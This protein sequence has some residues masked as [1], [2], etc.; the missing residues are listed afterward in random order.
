[1]RG[2]PRA[3]GCAP[4]DETHVARIQEA[5]CEFTQGQ[6]DQEVPTA[7]AYQLDGLTAEFEALIQP[8]Q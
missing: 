8:A 7:I 1:M 4:A 3:T 2:N 5:R 6:P